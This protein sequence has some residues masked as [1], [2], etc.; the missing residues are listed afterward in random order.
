MIL[1]IKFRNSSDLL[2]N[3]KHNSPTCISTKP[4]TESVL[5]IRFIDYADILQP[6]PINKIFMI[7]FKVNL[8]GNEFVIVI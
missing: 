3:T 5:K 6:V 1:A 2:K 4:V 7:F 8:V